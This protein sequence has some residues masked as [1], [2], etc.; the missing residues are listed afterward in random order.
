MKIIAGS[1]C[2]SSIFASSVRIRGQAISTLVVVGVGI[3][4][5]EQIE[6]A[7]AELERKGDAK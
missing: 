7:R 6:Q 5:D 1:H 2:R 4:A 3:N